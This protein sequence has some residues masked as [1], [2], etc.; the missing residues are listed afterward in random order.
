MTNLV[1]DPGQGQQFLNR[2]EYESTALKT[3]ILCFGKIDLIFPII[4]SFPL[5]MSITV[6]KDSNFA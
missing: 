6:L 1:N 3:T 4:S 5:S 2:F